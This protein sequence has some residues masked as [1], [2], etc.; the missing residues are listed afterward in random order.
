MSNQSETWKT[1]IGR[2]GLPNLN[3]SGA[4]LID[5]SANH[6]LSITNMKFEHKYWG[7]YPPDASVWCDQPLECSG[8]RAVS[9]QTQVLYSIAEYN[10][11]YKMEH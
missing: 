9:H 3:L 5:F 7:F 8:Q 2:N 1:V 10:P 6:S 4:L 11:T